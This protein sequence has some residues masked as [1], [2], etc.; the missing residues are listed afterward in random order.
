M[1]FF[2][3]LWRGHRLFFLLASIFGLINGTV[4]AAMISLINDNI[5]IMSTGSKGTYLFY[6]V[7]VG[8][9]LVSGFL[10]QSLAVS[11]SAKISF[12]LRMSMSRQIMST[13]LSDLERVGSA[14]L[15]ATFTDDIPAITSALLVIP[16]VLVNLAITSGCLVYLG[17]LSPFVMLVL[18]G[19]LVLSLVTYFLIERIGI[20]YMEATRISWDQLLEYFNA[21]N[22]GIKELKLHFARRHAF[23][24]GSLEET[25]REVYRYTLINQNI[26]A[27]LNNWVGLIY[28]LFVGL[29][30][31]FLAEHS[32]LDEKVIVGFVLVVLFVRVPIVILVDTIPSF[33]RAAVAFSMVEKI[34]M[35]FKHDKAAP[36][37]VV[38]DIMNKIASLPPLETLELVGVKHTYYREREERSFSLGPI[39]LSFKAGELVFIIG[40]N[41]S[42]KTT[43]AKLIAGL[44][45]PDEGEI[46][47]NGKAF[48]DNDRE[49]YMQY[50][51]AIFS[52][53][54]VF[55]EILG[56]NH[57]NL[58]NNAWEYARKLQ[59]DHKVSFHQG[60][61]STTSLSTGQ[62]KRLALLAAY[63]ED[64]PIYL[65]DEWAADQDPEFKEVFY[66]HLLPELKAKGKTV[67]VISHDDRFFDLADHLV[68]LADGRIDVERKSS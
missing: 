39:N 24:Y 14:R 2:K 36:T 42:G 56:L 5:A 55:D 16:V 54:Y 57:E 35:S 30:L 47:I 4:N 43:L 19:I 44:Y 66:R 8:C 65:F 17:F 58:D 32:D 28:F 10:T 1:I 34:G 41:G 52:D 11:L 45:H 6:F 60:K 20:R 61:L 15:Y 12:D 22:Q 18:M 7:L 31:F 26:Y 33:R 9:S 62:R 48:T 27:A 29:L 68:K 64:R 50:F 49:L 13:K 59:I 23:Y 21:M 25:G 37:N 40:G 3:F 67:L 38:S 46:L 63:L 51:S 53:F